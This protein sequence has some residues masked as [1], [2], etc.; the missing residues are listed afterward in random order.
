MISIDLDYP[1]ELGPGG[2]QLYYKYLGLGTIP[3]KGIKTVTIS[4]PEVSGVIVKSI[5]KAKNLIS[6]EALVLDTISESMLD[7]TRIVSISADLDQSELYA[8]EYYILYYI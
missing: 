1:F 6:G 5:A 4:S 7:N 3:N 2:E 8:T